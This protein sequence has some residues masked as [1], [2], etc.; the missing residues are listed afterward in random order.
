MSEKGKNFWGPPTW[1]IIHYLGF[2]SMKNPQLRI[3]YL[4]FVEML[5]KV[6]PCVECR[7]NL[8][9]K[10]KTR[11][12]S[13]T[14]NTFHY[15]YVLHDLANSHITPRKTSPP[16]NHVYDLYSRGYM[17]DYSFSEPALW[18]MVHS[19][20]TVIKPTESD[21]FE[22]FL[23]LVGLLLPSKGQIISDFV[24]IFP[25]SKYKSKHDTFYY[26]YCMH[27]FVN[28]QI[29]KPTLPYLEIKSTYFSALGESCSECGV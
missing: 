4:N 5:T 13:P 26:T 2:V 22:Q 6:L 10:L 7:K 8:A 23:S 3:Y 29:G 11:P 14:E 24:R 15:S 19:M 25:L 9:T 21:H 27:Y 16:F 12:I 1:T 17:K 20:A 28:E 18:A